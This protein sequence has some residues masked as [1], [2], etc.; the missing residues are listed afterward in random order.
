MG[1]SREAALP[2]FVRVAH[3]QHQGRRA[4]QIFPMDDAGIAAKDVG[5]DHAGHVDRVFG[6]TELGRIAKL[7]LLQVEHRSALLDRHRDDVD[8]PGDAFP[9]DGLGAHDP[10]VVSSKDQLD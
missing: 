8:A 3:I 10:A 1:G 9:A 2:E 7:R 6:G 4:F 5:R